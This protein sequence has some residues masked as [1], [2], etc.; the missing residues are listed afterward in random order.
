MAK[1]RKIALLEEN[2]ETSRVVDNTRGSHLW[3]YNHYRSRILTSLLN[4]LIELENEGLDEENCKMV[5]RSLEYF[6]NASTSVPKGGFLSGGPLYKE[7]ESFAATYKEWNDVNG[8]DEFNIQMRR[9]KVRELRKNRQR[10]SNKIRKLQYELENN[11]DQKV[12]HDSYNAIGDIIKLVPG[13]F[14]NLSS[15]YNDYLKKG[16]KA[17]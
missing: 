15:S 14:K 4:D 5:R 12:L 7:I 2:K 11:L 13:I 16:G 9:K 17:A 6:V 1:K 8:R 3:S 10:I